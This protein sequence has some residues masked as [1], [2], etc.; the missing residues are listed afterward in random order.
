MQQI[1]ECGVK[2]HY[3]L[4]R[5]AVFAILAV[6]AQIG[7]SAVQT[8]N[9]CQSDVEM[10]PVG[11]LNLDTALRN[12]GYIT[13]DCGQNATIR[14]TKNHEIKNSTTIDGGHQITL[15]AEGRTL[16]IFKLAADDLTFLMANIIIKG[17]KNEPVLKTGRHHGFAFAYGSVITAANNVHRKPSVLIRNSSIVENLNPILLELPLAFAQTDTGFLKISNSQ[18]NK[19]E[20]ISIACAD[21][22]VSIRNTRFVE[23]ETALSLYNSI[24]DIGYSTVFIRNTKG[25]IKASGTLN[26]GDTDFDSNNGQRGAAINISIG[27]TVSIRGSSFLHNHAAIAGGAVSIFRDDPNPNQ[28][29]TESEALRHRKASVSMSNVTFL[30]NTAARGGAVDM[31]VRDNKSTIAID[32]GIFEAN[33]ATANEGGAIG[34]TNGGI[35]KISRSIFK[36]NRAALTGG[37]GLFAGCRCRIGDRQFT[38]IQ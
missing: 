26:V 27:S 7:A 19:N 32:M 10:G 14:I 21:M 1:K 36:A 15:D 29:S 17:A 13:F 20:G 4:P 22:Q 35:V 6:T 3:L 34:G 8:V 18:F 28:S 16:T 12:G 37:G 2:N 30:G 31:D 24:G 11:K 33:E 9:L 5:A 25:A 38:D 23:N